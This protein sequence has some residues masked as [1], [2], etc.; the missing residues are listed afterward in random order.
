MMVN[1]FNK[2]LFKVVLNYKIIKIYVKH[3]IKVYIMMVINAV[4]Q[5][6]I[7]EY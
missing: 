2:I 3:V 1:V 6:N 7:Q 5:I 4:K